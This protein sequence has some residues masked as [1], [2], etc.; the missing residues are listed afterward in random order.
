MIGL[1]SNL[2]PVTVKCLHNRSTV[3]SE[4]TAGVR[5]F[6]KGDRDHKISKEHNCYKRGSFIVAELSCV[7]DPWCRSTT[8]RPARLETL[9]L[10]S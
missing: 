6:M 9:A 1:C 7:I 4:C 3:G 8:S 2:L 5:K 10:T